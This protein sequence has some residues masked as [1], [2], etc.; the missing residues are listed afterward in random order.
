MRVVTGNSARNDVAVNLK[1]GNCT[2]RHVATKMA[3]ENYAIN[4]V[5]VSLT[6]G[7]CD[8]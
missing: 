8:T 4:D 3:S 7:N 5:A 1:T 6:T 2:V